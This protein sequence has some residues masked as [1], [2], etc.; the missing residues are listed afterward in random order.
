MLH[1]DTQLIGHRSS[2]DAVVPRAH[3]NLLTWILR[4]SAVVL[5]GLCLI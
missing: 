5:F 3:P 4:S 2:S 1:W